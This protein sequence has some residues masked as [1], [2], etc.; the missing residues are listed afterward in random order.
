MPLQTH[1]STKPS[2]QHNPDI[3][4]TRHHLSEA[5]AALLSLLHWLNQGTAFNPTD[6]SSTAPLAEELARSATRLQDALALH[7]TPLS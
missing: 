3:W 4:L 2:S 6:D 1:T 7:S 5:N